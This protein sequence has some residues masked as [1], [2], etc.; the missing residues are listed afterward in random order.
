MESRALKLVGV[1][2]LTLAAGFACSSDKDDDGTGPE[3]GVEVIQMS[4]RRFT[5]AT[6]TIEPGT[7]V[8]WA[9]DDEAHTITP[10]NSNQPG[11]WQDVVV[12]AGEEFEH[13]FEVA[14]QT[15]DYECQF[16]EGMTGRIIVSE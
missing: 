7:T 10:A 15:Y 5:P 14:G 3:E 12:E 13:T 2:A 1:F 4:N 16:H 8:R 11:V 6:L 9:K